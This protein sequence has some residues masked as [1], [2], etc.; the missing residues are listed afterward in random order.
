VTGSRPSIFIA[1]PLF[2][3]WEHVGHTLETIRAQSYGNFRVLIS[4]DGGDRRSRE[5]CRPVFD[6]ERFEIVLHEQR[7]GWEGNINYL[8]GRFVGDYFCYWQHDDYCDPAYLEK[9]VAHAAEHPEASAV[10]CDM[11]IFGEIEH[12]AS[13]RSVR[14]FA[15]QRVLAQMRK[16]HPAAIRCLIRGDALLAA[17]PIKLATT[18][19]MSLARSGELHRVPELLYYRRIRPQALEY[20]MPKR[21]AGEMW[22]ASLDWGLGVLENVSPLVGEA[23]RAKLFAMVV[24]RI[25]RNK[26]P[27][28]YKYNFAKTSRALNLRFVHDLVEEAERDLGLRPYPE[29]DRAFLESRAAT[30]AYAS[31]DIVV[32]ALLAEDFVDDEAIVSEYVPFVFEPEGKNERKAANRRRRRRRARPAKRKRS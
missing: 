20:T 3:G 1:M 6:D 23:E 31:E 29:T 18:W 16:P 17:L 32:E 8:G 14:G 22:R 19:L 4:V 26:V 13:Q 15:L 30:P 2:E 11:K 27:G 21:P 10:Y 7:L 5:A 25:V 28:R 12:I 9:L 24:K